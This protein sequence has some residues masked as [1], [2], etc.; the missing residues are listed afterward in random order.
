MLS[1]LFIL[2]LWTVFFGFR[3]VAHSD[4][5]RHLFFGFSLFYFTKQG[6]SGENSVNVYNVNATLNVLPKFSTFFSTFS[7]SVL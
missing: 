7:W 4:F 2:Y 1:T 3:L 6:L 5:S